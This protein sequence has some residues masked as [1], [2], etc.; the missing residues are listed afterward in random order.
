MRGLQS[1]KAMKTEIKQRHKAPASRKRPKGATLVDVAYN[2]IKRRILTNEFAP[3]FQ[4]TESQLAELLGVSRTPVREAL[5]R[6]EKEQLVENIPRHGM[7]VLPVS[8]QEMLEIYQVLTALESQAVYLLAQRPVENRGVQRLREYLQG[9]DDALEDGSIQKWAE[10]DGMFHR[11]LFELCGN[12][13]LM[14]AGLGFREQVDRAR[15]VTLPLRKP[16]IT[17]NKSHRELIDLIEKGDAEGAF[18]SHWKHR[19]RATA[20]LTEILKNFQWLGL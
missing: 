1:D 9:M 10:A 6:L 14:Q 2:E 15:L 5:I 16:P 8:A 7:R 13:K 19:N 17:S 18:G 20:E 12:G 4:I 11:S 3:N